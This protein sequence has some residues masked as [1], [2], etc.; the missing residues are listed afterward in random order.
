MDHHGLIDG[1]RN[2]DLHLLVGLVS[3]QSLTLDRHHLLLAVLLL[4]LVSVLSPVSLWCSTRVDAHLG[5]DW[6]GSL[7][8]L[9]GHTGH[10]H[11]APGAGHGAGVG[12]ETAVPVAGYG[13]TP[14]SV[15]LGNGRTW[16]QSGLD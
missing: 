1:G 8:G 7:T 4:G 14:L 9:A 2:L 16:W 5:R 10:A 13:E 3:L 12:P 11:V 15:L 6:L